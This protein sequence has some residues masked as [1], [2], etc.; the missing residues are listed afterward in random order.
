MFGTKSDKFIVGWLTNSATGCYEYYVNTPATDLYS[1]C[2]FTN[3][4]YCATTM[5]RKEANELARSIGKR[6]ILNG[7]VASYPLVVSADD[8]MP[9]E[10]TVREVWPGGALAD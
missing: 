4:P 9:I 7:Y 5:T 10:T 1:V 8:H 3:N 6:A 2:S